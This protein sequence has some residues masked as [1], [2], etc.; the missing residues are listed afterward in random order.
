MGAYEI[1]AVNPQARDWNST[2]GGPM[3]GYR[4]TMRDEAGQETT[5]VEWSRKV[6]SPPPSVGQSVEGL[7]DMAAQ[8]GPKFKQQSNSGGGGG[9]QKSPEE[10][11]AIQRMHDQDM[12]LRAVDLAV[13]LGVAQPTTSAELF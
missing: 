5:N 1:T 8:Y 2:K 6:T 3:K 13:K 9:Y 10:R 11:A 7:I 4:V 12:A